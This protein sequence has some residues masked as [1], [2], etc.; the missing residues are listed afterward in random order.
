MK[1]WALL[2]FTF[3]SS[4]AYAAQYDY[5]KLRFTKFKEL[6]AVKTSA[7]RASRQYDY[8]KHPLQA[9]KPLKEAL[10]MFYSRPNTDN[11]IRTLSS[12]IEAE[13]KMMG[14]FEVT[15]KEI[16]KENEELVFD[17]SQAYPL[18]ATAVLAMNNLL[19]EIKP[20]ILENTDL[21]RLTC[22]AAD[23]DLKVPKDI[24][25]D[26]QLRSMMTHASPSK[27]AQSIMRWY[28]DKKGKK[29]GHSAQGCPFSKK[30]T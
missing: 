21:A 10:K 29:V 3:F 16:L 22:E 25:N 4:S 7:L 14:A 8:K 6:R 24:Q 9:R 2:L 27:M 19:L 18:R 12:D 26:S 17:K 5:N 20:Q 23:K 1:L 15:L 13:L 30:A 28:A 11:L